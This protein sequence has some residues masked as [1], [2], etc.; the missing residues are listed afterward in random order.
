[1]CNKKV[2]I[3]ELEY[4]RDK[5]HLVNENVDYTSCGKHIKYNEDKVYFD[6]SLQIICK[7]CQN[8]LINTIKDIENYWI[9]NNYLNKKI[10]PIG[11][12]VIII[13]PQ[14]YL[15]IINKNGKCILYSKHFN[16][17]IEIDRTFIQYN[18]QIATITGYGA[19][20]T[21]LRSEHTGY[22]LDISG[23][24]V[25]DDKFFS[26]ILLKTL[27]NN[28]SYFNNLENKLKNYRYEQHI[29]NKKIQEILIKKEKDEK[30]KLQ[31]FNYI[32][33]QIEVR[34]KIINLTHEYT[35]LLDRFFNPLR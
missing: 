24:K 31:E 8:N 20:P 32:K 33:D 10:F 3:A 11:T 2:M 22:E 12:D 23:N 17:H 13:I 19:Y 18:N 28:I 5:I 6:D 29:E 15:K 34:E 16:K 27:S 4:D 30:E 7:I 35:D 14:E 26:S 9:S 25:W 21:Y 1:M